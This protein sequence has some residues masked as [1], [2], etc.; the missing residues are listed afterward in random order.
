MSEEKVS[1]W[2]HETKDKGAL[3]FKKG[4]NPTKHGSKDSKNMRHANNDEYYEADDK[5]KGKK[6]PSRKKRGKKEI[7]SYLMSKESDR[8]P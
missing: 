7:E 3:P 6:P 4:G 2:E 1:E 8:K 5:E